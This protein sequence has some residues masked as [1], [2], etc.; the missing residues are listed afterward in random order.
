MPPTAAGSNTAGDSVRGTNS[1]SL[2]TVLGKV[3]RLNKDGKKYYALVNRDDR[4]GGSNMNECPD[5][6]I[7][8]MTA[9][10]ATTMLS[11]A[12]HVPWDLFPPH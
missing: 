5:A 4:L 1:Q 3:L 2:N 7:V 8:P 6:K 10:D 12:S 11:G 9:D